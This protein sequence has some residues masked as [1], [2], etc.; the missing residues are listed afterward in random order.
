MKQEFLMEALSGIGDDLIR[1][2]ETRRFPNPWRR[3]GKLAACI[4]LVLCLGVLALP[5]L[6]M[7][8]GAAQ[9]PEMAPAASA[10]ESAPMESPA[11][12]PIADEAPAEEPMEPPK[13]DAVSEEA[14]EGAGTYPEEQVSILFDGLWYELHS[15]PLELPEDL[16]DE[17]GVV[18]ESDGRDLAGCPVY[19]AADSEDLYVRLPEGYLRAV[20]T[21]RQT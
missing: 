11:D 7:G 12:F 10:P 18:E 13:Q 9:A 6:P 20:P 3:W 19:A 17:L 15:P 16:G 5:W 21:D 1:L 14:P 8:C 2:A 4:A